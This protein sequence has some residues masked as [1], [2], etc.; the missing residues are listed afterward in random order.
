MNSLSSEGA[1]NERI[2]VMR[3][4]PRPLHLD[5]AFVLFDGTQKSGSF[6]KRSYRATYKKTFEDRNVSQPV[7]VSFFIAPS[8]FAREQQGIDGA[9]EAK[10]GPRIFDYGIDFNPMGSPSDGKLPYIVEEYLG[11]SL[12]E[13]LTGEMAPRLIG[14]GSGICLCEVGSKQRGRQISKL[15]FDIASALKNLHTSRLYYLD[16]KLE[17]VCVQAYGPD[18]ADI[19]ASLVDFESLSRNKNRPPDLSTKEC[20]SKL[21]G[22]YARCK[23]LFDV[24]I[25]NEV[26]DCGFLCLLTASLLTGEPLQKLDEK[27]IDGAIAFL[28]QN[29]FWAGRK[30]FFSEGICQEDLDGLAR[31]AGLRKATAADGE[32][33]MRAAELADRG[34]YI[35][36]VD[37]IR[38]E[39]DPVY[40]LGKRK[41]EIAIE[42]HKEYCRL[43]VEDANR[44][45]IIEDFLNQ[46]PLKIQQGFRQAL[47]MQRFIERLGYELVSMDLCPQQ[48]VMEFDDDEIMQIAEWEHNRWKELHENNGLI[49]GERLPDGRRP[50]G[51]NEYLLSWD[52]LCGKG[53]QVPDIEYAKSVIGRLAGAGLAVV[54]PGFN[55]LSDLR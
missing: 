33:A 14:K 9:T 46:P 19:R 54:D 15:I 2:G 10:V 4:R 12:A 3:F 25:S 6:R 55:P 49:Y 41:L 31:Q 30:R 34:G 17:N 39:M 28:G 35:D 40:I 50:E 5:D 20:Y 23:G 32:D 51:K 26:V 44:N 7:W 37:M 8:W 29:I 47:D 38:L 16:L 22:E 42:C 24:R 45:D 53:R 52:E 43:M 48:R 11:I 18:Q 13:M 21:F 36:A 1:A 27:A